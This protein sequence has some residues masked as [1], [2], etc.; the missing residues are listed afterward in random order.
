MNG[1]SAVLGQLGDEQRERGG[2]NCGKQRSWFNW[3]SV[4]QSARETCGS[5]SRHLMVRATSGCMDP[6]PQIG[7]AHV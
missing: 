7:R 5:N 1:A 4:K 3:S 6:S 2:W